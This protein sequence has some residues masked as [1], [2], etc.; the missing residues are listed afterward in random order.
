MPTSDS[1]IYFEV[2]MPASGWNGKFKG[3]G[4]GGFAGSIEYSEMAPDLVRG[5]ATSSTDT[6]STADGSFALGHPQKIVDFGYRA[7]HE[8]AMKGEAITQTFYG[9]SPKHSYNPN[10]E[11]HTWQ[12]A[13]ANLHYV[14]MTNRFSPTR[15]SRQR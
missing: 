13:P 4:N 3:N 9:T 5:Y 2:W 10:W 6:G 15:P 7:H 12:W 1:D 11:F 14:A 8:L